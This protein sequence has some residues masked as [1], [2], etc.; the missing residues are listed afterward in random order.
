MNIRHVQLDDY[1]PIVTVMDD[2]W[3]GR[4]VSH[5]LP[6]LFFE[7]FRN[8]SF[9]IEQ[10][11]K[12]IRQDDPIIAFLVGFLSQSQPDEAYIHFVG[13][14]PGYR[15]RRLGKTLY[16][17][18]FKTVRQHNCTIVRCITSPV[19]TGS[20][21]FHTRLGFQ[22]EPQDTQANGVSYNTDHDG[23]GEPRVHFV[24]HI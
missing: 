16:E 1:L 24:K 6:R 20:I 11:D 7:H 3:G 15:D 13:V 18:F 2:W 17:L 9:V 5:L 4:R 19:N 8:T 21:A 14:H 22:I 23:L 12:I 10:D